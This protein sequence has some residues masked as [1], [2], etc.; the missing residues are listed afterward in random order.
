VGVV[1]LLNPN[2]M[3]GADA[4]PKPNVPVKRTADTREG[5]SD[6][7]S[8]ES[9]EERRKKRKSR[10]ETE[11]AKTCIPGLPTM[12]P[13]GLTKDQE[14]A[15]LLQLK[16]EDTTRRLRA[17]DL[18]IPPNPEDRSPSPEPIYSSDG[19]RLN[20]REYRKRKQ[21]EEQ[22]H[23]AV[24]KMMLLN[25]EFKPP[26]DYRA[27]MI[28]V[29]DKVMIPQEHH[30]DIN[31]MGLII[32][33]RGNTLKALEKETGAKIIIRGKGSVKEGKVG[34]N[35][36]QPLPGE[37]EPLHA[38]ITSTDADCVKRAVNRVKQIIQEG[39]DR[40][41]GSNELRKIQLRELAL[42]NGT[43]R[44]D[45]IVR[46][47]NCGADN[48]KSWQCQDKANV[49]NSVT[50][51]ACGGA[52]HIATDCKS[53]R[54]GASFN[55]Q[56]PGGPGGATKID[57]EYM[58]LMAELG[59]GPPPPP[60]GT[61]DGPAHSS[62]GG[63]VSKFDQRP[64]EA[65]MGPP[66]GG[67][68]PP[69]PPSL[70]SV[71]TGGRGGFGG[72]GPDRR[73]NS[74]DRPMG[75]GWDDNRGRNDDRNG[76]GPPRHNDRGGG[77]NND[78]NNDRR[79][80]GG[81]FGG[82]RGGGGGGRGGGPGGPG[83]Q[84]DRGGPMGGGPMG[85]GPVPPPWAGGNNQGPNNNWNNGPRGPPGGNNWNGP[86]P[87]N[88]GGP[89]MGWNGPNNGPPG[90]PNFGGGNQGGGFGGPPPPPPP[91]GG[92][93]GPGGNFG[94]MGPGWGGGQGAP[95]PVPPPPRA[96]MPFW[97]PQSGG[98]SAL[99]GLLGAPPPPPPPS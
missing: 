55:N 67:G 51:S 79:G 50:C 56:G 46:C 40:P 73:D 70:M 35:N 30:P 75:R 59:E 5:R 66:G 12:I 13:A 61:G 65:L 84:M 47:T 60:P 71:N 42:L 41:E 10:W 80:S 38:Y 49:T 21:Q 28:K 86:G 36:G 62:G 27:P 48:H 3:G 74:R 96:P 82:G 87:N 98:G 90:P 68:A 17:G 4:A 88:R 43:L 76:G 6:E 81:G 33:P 22:R 31:F 95:A 29:S 11:S 78:R 34:R 44:E 94:G 24:Q 2:Y 85:G 14:Q 54:P 91:A 53:R 63:R 19:K 16:I 99:S 93:G 15:Y 39:V 72:P 18:G 9:R 89:P 57:R 8:S 92:R 1:S 77:W 23:E 69:G 58:S 7:K 83:G 26:T 64:P 97:A 25:P 52:G 20:T 32:G 45:G 37:N